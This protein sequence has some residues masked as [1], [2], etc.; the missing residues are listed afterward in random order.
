MYQILRVQ[1]VKI[2]ALLSAAALVVVQLWH[3]A[4]RARDE[5]RMNFEYTEQGRQVGRN[6]YLLE[7]FALALSLRQ[8]NNYYPQF[9]AAV[10]TV[11]LCLNIQFEFSGL[12][13]PFDLFSISQ[14]N[15]VQS[16]N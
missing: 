6:L 2:N 15:E 11:A 3:G 5:V 13:I 4:A 1:N 14:R 16:D 7:K 10:T 8:R 12:R 9:G